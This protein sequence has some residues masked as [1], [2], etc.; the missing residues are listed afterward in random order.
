MRTLCPVPVSPLK[1][2]LL[3]EPRSHQAADTLLMCKLNAIFYCTK[4]ASL[5]CKSLLGHYAWAHAGNMMIVGSSWQGL[6]YQ[7]LNCRKTSK[8]G[9]VYTCL[10][11]LA[12]KLFSKQ[13]CIVATYKIS[14]PHTKTVQLAYCNFAIEAAGKLAILLAC[15]VGV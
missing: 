1:V 6:L 11:S 13:A 8:A 7:Q 3:V 10:A 14:L 2:G 15:L 9:V 12:K 5:H 4:G